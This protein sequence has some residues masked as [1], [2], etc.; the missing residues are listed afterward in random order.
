M[1][2]PV[3]RRF[4]GLPAH[5]AVRGSRFAVVHVGA[6]DC[7]AGRQF[8]G[9]SG[10]QAVRRVGAFVLPRAVKQPIK[11][12]LR[13]TRWF[14]ET[15]KRRP[16]PVVVK[17]SPPRPPRRR[18]YD[19]PLPPPP[20]GEVSPATLHVDVPLSMYVARLLAEKPL[21][22]YEPYGV[23]A[24]LCVLERAAPGAAFDIGANI[25]IY[26]L[27][28]AAY[29]DRA[30]HAFEPAPDTAQA[31]REIAAA[32]GLSMVV[33]EIALGEQSGTATL[34]LSDSTDSSNSLNPEFREHSRGIQV[35]L[36][37]L[38]DYVARTGAV[39]AVIKVDTETTEHQVL[40]GAERTIREHRP[41]ILCEVLYG[42]SE[43]SLH[44]VM[45]RHG[46]TIYHLNGPGPRPVVKRMVGDDSWIYYMFLFA[47]EPVGE[48]FWD[49]MAQWR[50]VLATV[51]APQP[52]PVPIPSPAPEPALASSDR[53]GRPLQLRSIPAG[54]EPSRREPPPSDRVEDHV[55]QIRCDTPQAPST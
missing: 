35:P 21:A 54:R 16:K 15:R 25:G 5:H 46:Y 14:P 7:Y 36:E 55:A 2:D 33:N 51:P 17:P 41:W 28:A 10:Y 26:G 47:P 44:A 48:D 45:D 29:D 38:D 50:E 52:P 27:L 12:R 53:P 19:L 32:S 34:Y 30:V 18:V 22:A 4:C 39:P 3:S 42:L 1:Q 40:A 8:M 23:D 37:R 6:G 49:R 31:A 9:F 11:D 43:D 24:F 13:G 20:G